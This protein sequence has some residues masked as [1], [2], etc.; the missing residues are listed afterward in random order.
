MLLVGILGAIFVLVPLQLQKHPA[1]CHGEP[2]DDGRCDDEPEDD[3]RCDGEPVM[4]SSEW[5]L[6]DARYST[7][8][9]T[10][11]A[12]S[13][14]VRHCLPTSCVVWQIQAQHRKAITVMRKTKSTC[15]TVG[16]RGVI[17]IA[18]RDVLFHKAQLLLF[19]FET[20]LCVRTH[21]ASRA[22]QPVNDKLY[23]LVP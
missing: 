9:P 7:I 6:H 12:H 16:F 19:R 21:A 22:I 8:E 10:K 11:R 17:G 4:E 23:L 2:E 13:P 1:C 3:G 14:D 5:S 20:L 18:L 15:R